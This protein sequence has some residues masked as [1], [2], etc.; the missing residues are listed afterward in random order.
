MAVNDHE[1]EQYGVLVVFLSFL[2]SC[3]LNVT[4]MSTIYSLSIFWYFQGD[5]EQG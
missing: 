5:N 1:T 3:I 4:R 2:Y